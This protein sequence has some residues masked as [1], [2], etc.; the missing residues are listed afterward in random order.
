[1]ISDSAQKAT[2]ISAAGRKSAQ[3]VGEGIVR[4]RQQMEAIAASMMQLSEQG[5]SIIQII[6]V[7]EGLASQS[8]LLAVNAAIEAGKAGEQ[9]KGLQRRGAGSE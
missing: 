4:I 1:M 7:V 9:G 3:D 6:A 5:Q 2:H 8:N